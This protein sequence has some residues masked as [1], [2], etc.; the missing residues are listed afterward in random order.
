MTVFLTSSPC[1]EGTPELNPLNGFVDKLM[2][3]IPNPAHG[4]FVSASPSEIEQTE[5]IAQGMKESVAEAG[6][7]FL[8]FHALH[9]GNMDRAAE[10]VSQAD[11]I[12]LSGGHV[13]T[14]N[15]FI[16]QI[17]LP[18]LMQGFQGVVMGI[19]AG[20][21]NCAST[22]YSIPELD[23]ETLDPFYHRF[24]AGLG[25]TQTMIIPHFQKLRHYVLDGKRMVQDIAFVDSMNRRFYCLP[26]GS[27]IFRKGAR[28]ELHGPAWLIHNGTLSVANHEGEVLLLS[29]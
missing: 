10:L 23:G 5:A 21:M 9:H 17:S 6:A 29:E 1:R 19:S 8:S 18:A 27:Y 11:F 3:E 7:N 20:S 16:Q 15:R 22:V 12:V 13:P 28:E 24:L 2:R 25:L 26:D 4:L 14:Q